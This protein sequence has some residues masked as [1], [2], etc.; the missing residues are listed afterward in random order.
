[1]AAIAIGILLF[2]LTLRYVNIRET[3]ESASRL[4]F[5]LPLILL[6]GTLWQVLRTWGWAVSFPDSQR[7]AFTRLFRV[8]LAADAIAFFTI[9]GLAGEPLKVVLLYDRTAPEVCTAAIALERLAF[10]VIGTL[11][12]GVISAFAVSRL[13]LP[14]AWETVFRLLTMAAFVMMVLL[15]LVSMAPARAEDRRP[16]RPRLPQLL[17][18]Q[19][20]RRVRRRRHGGD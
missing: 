12:A 3:I 5:A 20:P 2:A 8:R 7:P 10:A 17:S 6:P 13:S 11:T 15:A 18:Q 1:M 4:G 19:E 9:R 14:D 16:G